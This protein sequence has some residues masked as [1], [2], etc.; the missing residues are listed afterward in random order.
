MKNSILLFVI[1]FNAT[2]SL[3]NNRSLYVDNFNNILGNYNL[4]N[5]LLEFSKKNKINTLILYELHKVNKILPLADSIKNNVLANFIS[6]AKLEFG[7]EKISASGETGDFFLNAIH[8]YNKSRK[9]PEEKFDIYNLEYEY[10]NDEHSLNGG[11]Y[12]ETYLKKGQTPCSRVGSFYYYV[13]ALS[14]MKLL[15]EEESHPVKIEAYIG[16]FT[17]EEILKVV[18]HT[19]ILLLHAYVKNPRDSYSYTK[20]R[21]D[22]LS[23]INAKI[24]ISILFSSEMNFMGT[25]LKSNAYSTAEEIFFDELHKDKKELRDKLNLSGFTY[26]TYN[27]LKKS[28]NTYRYFNNPKN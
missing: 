8:P 9:K 12:C 28:I 23:S 26:Y 25:W 17:K 13:E 22:I 11:Y 3:G 15:A 6:R 20:E 2:I 4:E 5:E 27:F 10:W 16:K 7:I 19:D 21:L 24:E 18:K 14:I 1:F